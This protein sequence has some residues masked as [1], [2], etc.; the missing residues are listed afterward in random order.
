MEKGGGPVD[1]EL[2][3]LFDLSHDAFCIAGLDGYLNRAN[4]AFARSLGYS[5]DELLAGRS[6]TTSTPMTSSR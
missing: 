4:P 3:G 1:E 6:W 5:L 2:V